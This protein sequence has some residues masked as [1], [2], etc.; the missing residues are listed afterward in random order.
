MAALSLLEPTVASSV[1]TFHTPPALLTRPASTKAPVLGSVTP[2]GSPTAASD[3]PVTRN[4]PFMRDNLKR[5][6]TVPL[7]VSAALPD[8]NSST[9]GTGSASPSLRSKGV[10]PAVRSLADSFA[11]P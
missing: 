7:K 8:F 11:G 6:V 1:S 9:I 2:S 3:G 5:S 4:T 10:T